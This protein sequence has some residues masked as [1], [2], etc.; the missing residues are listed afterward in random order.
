[1]E[2]EIHEALRSLPFKSTFKWVKGCHAAQCDN[3][4]KEMPLSQEAIVND[5]AD[6]LAGGCLQQHTQGTRAT[7]EHTPHLPATTAT[8]TIKG[9]QVA[10][11]LQKELCKSINC[12]KQADCMMELND[13]PKEMFHQVGWDACETAIKKLR[14][15]LKMRTIKQGS[16]STKKAHEISLI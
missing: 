1:M 5:K 3:D 2:S 4:G 7:S 8:M 6:M 11:S 14:N 16:V 10:S 15:K 13:W 9:K 12:E